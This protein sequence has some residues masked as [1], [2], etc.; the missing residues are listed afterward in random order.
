MEL[1]AVKGRMLQGLRSIFLK[2]QMIRMCLSKSLQGG[3]SRPGISA[4]LAVGF[5]I[6]DPCCCLR[7]RRLLLLKACRRGTY[8]LSPGLSRPNDLAEGNNPGPAAA[9]GEHGG[10]VSR[11]SRNARDTCDK[12]I[13]L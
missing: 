8:E 10:L 11:A 13:Q 5:F 6:C 1:G 12:E 7:L 4:A 9:A 3:Q 2:E